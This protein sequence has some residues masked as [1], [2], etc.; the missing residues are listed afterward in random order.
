MSSVCGDGVHGSD[1]ACSLSAAPAPE[2]RV[3]MGVVYFCSAEQLLM[4]LQLQLLASI[5]FREGAGPRIL[6]TRH[7]R[8]ERPRRVPEP[9]LEFCPAGSDPG[10]LGSERGGVSCWG[11]GGGGASF[12]HQLERFQG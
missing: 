7:R 10:F 11:G 9:V 12:V 8:E 1:T 6:G 4:S 2:R 5:I 3:Q